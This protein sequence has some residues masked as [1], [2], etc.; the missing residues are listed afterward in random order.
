MTG[1]VVPDTVHATEDGNGDLVLLNR[2]TGR[3]HKL[4]GT[5]ADVFRALRSAADA[6]QAIHVLTDRHPDVP[7]DRIRADVEHL[8]AGLV[9]RGLLVLADDVRRGAAAVLMASPA[10]SR[11]HGVRHRVTAAF[12]FVLALVL[13]R[14][15]FRITTAAVP[16]FRAALA[17][18][19][20][21]TV[22]ALSVLSAVY[23]VSRF[24]PGR[25]A[26]LEVSLTAVLAAALLGRRI[27]WCFGT[28]VDPQT[29]HAWIEV[30][31]EPVTDPAE[32]PIPPTYR[33][34]LLV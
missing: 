6:E 2:V 7:A 28:A 1:F 19:N 33:R 3:W 23:R 14:L 32:D 31:G 34:V 29:F 17:H 22:E 30:D 21:S 18:R 11:G 8:L 24:Y 9:A 4:N 27:D 5:G 25:V 26:C 13:L 10:P 20:A 16:R 12:A 15:P